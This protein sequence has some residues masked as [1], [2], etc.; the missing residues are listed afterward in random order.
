MSK[1][2]VYNVL[3][4]Y[5][6]LKI[7]VMNFSFIPKNKEPRNRCLFTHKIR[8]NSVFYRTFFFKPRWIVIQPISLPENIYLCSQFLTSLTEHGQTERGICYQKK[9]LRFMD[10]KNSLFNDHT[11][12]QFS[13]FHTALYSTFLMAHVVLGLAWL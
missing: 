11:I 10:M 3:G 12:V 4:I 7:W 8:T 1:N 5:I 13:C 2:I 6:I 9:P